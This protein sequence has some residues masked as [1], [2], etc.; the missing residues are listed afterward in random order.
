MHSLDQYVLRAHGGTEELRRGVLLGHLRAQ[1]Q[2]KD[3][4]P[5]VALSPSWLEYVESGTDRILEFPIWTFHA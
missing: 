3:S 2:S 4:E 1:A 5:L